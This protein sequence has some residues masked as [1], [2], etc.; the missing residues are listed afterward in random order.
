MLRAAEH[1]LLAQSHLRRCQATSV[2]C[3]TKSCRSGKGSIWLHRW[4]N[5]RVFLG[6]L[7]AEHKV[8]LDS[9]AVISLTGGNWRLLC[10]C[11]RVHSK[12]VCVKNSVP[13]RYHLI[14]CVFLFDKCT[15]CL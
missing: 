6:C 13:F 3:T 12:S 8:G 2:H 10:V 5:V 9:S 1:L 15:N 14:A 7:P 4:H 11:V